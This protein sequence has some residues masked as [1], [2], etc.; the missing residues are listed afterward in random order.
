MELSLG[1][2]ADLAY[3]QIELD[4]WKKN[5]CKSNFLDLHIAKLEALNQQWGRGSL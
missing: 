1:A 5:G 4:W 2:S 3:L